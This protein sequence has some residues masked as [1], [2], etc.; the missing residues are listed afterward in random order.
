MPGCAGGSP[1]IRPSSIEARCDSADLGRSGTYRSMPNR[2]SRLLAANRKNLALMRSLN[3]RNGIGAAE[4]LKHIVCSVLDAGSRPM[5]S[6]G[7]LGG[8]FAEEKSIWN[9]Q[10]RTKNEIGTHWILHGNRG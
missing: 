10:K 7:C 4:A 9:V 8:E 1:S 6:A 3:I 5:E 2:R